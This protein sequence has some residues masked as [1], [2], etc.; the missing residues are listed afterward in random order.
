MP[1]A[2]VMITNC[3]SSRPLESTKLVDA[4]QWS[5]KDSLLL[6]SA[7]RSM[8]LMLELNY[9]IVMPTVTVQA[10]QDLLD[11]HPR[12]PLTLGPYTESISVTVIAVGNPSRKG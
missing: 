9:D 7:M 3:S 12:M 11:I 6:I 10:L 4:I 5:P 8:F 1:H 2:G